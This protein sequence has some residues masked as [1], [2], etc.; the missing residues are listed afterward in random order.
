MDGL[1]NEVVLVDE[2][3]KPLATMDKM[4]AHHK[5]LLHRAFSVFIFNQHGQILLQQRAQNK[6]H[7]AGL[8]TNACCSH[9]LLNEPVANGAKERLAYE[10]GLLCNLEFLF[11]FIYNAAVENGLI[12]HE[13]DHVFVG[14]TNTTPVPSPS[15]VQAWRW[16]TIPSLLQ[17]MAQKPDR[18]TVW[19]KMA[20]PKVLL[21]LR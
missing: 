4:E 20:L 9:P 5:G 1:R 8:W 10:M 17:E 6:Y 16:V 3:D 11:S 15:E 13:Y 21:I 14:T 12:E 7:G 18:F 19:F 2:N